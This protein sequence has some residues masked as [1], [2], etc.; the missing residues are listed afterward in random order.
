MLDIEALYRRYAE[1]L[2]RC[3]CRRFHSTASEALV[4]DA[5]STAWLIAWTKRDQ[6][7]AENAFAWLYTV[8]LHEMFRLL[9][10]Q[11]RELADDAIDLTDGR[12]SPELALRALE[13]IELLARL[14]PN[15]RLALGLQVAG[16]SYTESAELTGKTFT[17]VN[18]HVSEGR[19][20]V[21][22]LAKGKGH[23]Q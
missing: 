1:D 12:T 23:S 9:R 11:R 22:K 3:L 10:S 19:A 7:R 5:C 16:Y 20:A 6:L 4:E 21:R 2:R 18:R 17:W 14:T 15:Q 13:A 8:A